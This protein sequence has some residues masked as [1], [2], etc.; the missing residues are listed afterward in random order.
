MAETRTFQ[1]THP[2]INFRPDLRQADYTLW[3]QLG[4]AQAK[5]EQVAGVPLLPGVAENLHQ[6]FLAKGALATT[7]IEGNTLT[8]EDALKLI[9]G[10]LDLPPSKEYL[11]QEIQNIIDVM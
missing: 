4:E 2:W 7:A 1:K 8:E 5:C 11:G 6:V 10:E 9:K 3:I